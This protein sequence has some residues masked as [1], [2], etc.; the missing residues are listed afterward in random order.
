MPTLHRRVQ[1]PA[2]PAG[3]DIPAEGDA[4]RSKVLVAR[5]DNLGDVLLAGPAVRAVATRAEVTMAVGPRGVAAARLLPGVARIVCWDA[6][7]V[8]YTPPRV[9]R[10]D[11]DRLLQVLGGLEFDEALVLTSFHQSPLPL[12][13]LLRLAGIGRIAATSVDYPGSLLD[14]RHPVDPRAHEV[15]QALSLAA[16]AIRSRHVRRYA[17]HRAG[18][19]RSTRW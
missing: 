3:C 18:S 10:A 7:W 8:G 19:V 9:D 12:A 4:P 13:L 1:R 14:V 16:A 6:P 15:E 17:R 2:I 5:L 11:V